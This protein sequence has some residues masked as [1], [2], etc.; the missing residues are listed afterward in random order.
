MPVEDI[1]E[2]KKTGLIS[3]VLWGSDLPV[4]RYFY[5]TS[6]IEYYEERIKEVRK[7]LGYEDF[8][9]I[10]RKNFNFFGF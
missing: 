4:M 6:V 9:K 3:R 10:T 7:I 1:L 5:K 2:L 8:E